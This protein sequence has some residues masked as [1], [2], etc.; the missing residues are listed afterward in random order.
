MESAPSHTS[1]G[2]AYMVVAVACFVVADGIA[3]WGGGEGIHPIEIAFFRY[4]FGLVPMVLALR[5]SGPGV[6]ATRNPLGHLIRA[7]LMWASMVLFFWGLKY[8]PL[9]EAIAIGFT[10][11]LFITALSWPILKEK[12]GPHRWAAVAAGFAGMLI[13]VKPGTQGIRPE[14]LLVI[15]SA[16]TYSLGALY[17]RRVART[18]HST[19]IF[20]YTTLFA[21]LASAPLAFLVWTPLEPI[22]IAGFAVLGIVGGAAH[23]MVIIAYYNAPA[24]VNAPFEYTALV[25]GALFGWVFWNE[26]LPLSSWLGAAIIVASGLYITWRETRRRQPVT[27]TV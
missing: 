8:M 25:W 21:L 16:L 4:L 22:H 7:I 15:A 11:P 6:L 3:K 13:I 19:A 2:I 12:V 1:K 24:A 27:G 18:E 9:A 20:T 23:L 10:A 26:H 5:T 14:A 17:T